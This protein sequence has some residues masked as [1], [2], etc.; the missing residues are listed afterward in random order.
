VR[1]RVGHVSLA[2]I[3]GFP[4]ADD[5]RQVTSAGDRMPPKSTYFEPKLWSGLL[6]RRLDAG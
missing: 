5:L 3:V 2:F 6:M 1:A 4:T